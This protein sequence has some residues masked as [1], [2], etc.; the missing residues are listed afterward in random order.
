MNESR[1]IHDTCHRMARELEDLYQALRLASTAQWERP[2]GRSDVAESGDPG[3]HE[4]VSNGKVKQKNQISD[5][6]GGIVTDDARM[7]VR[8]RLKVTERELEDLEGHLRG[9]R[10]RLESSLRPYR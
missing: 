8:H 1:R 6:T 9:T 7:S 3:T 5:P 4:T 10:A 2:P